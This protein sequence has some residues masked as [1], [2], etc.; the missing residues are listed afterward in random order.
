[1]PYVLAV[2]LHGGRRGALLAHPLPPSRGCHTRRSS[3]SSTS[4][5]RRR[6]RWCCSRTA[7]G[8][9]EIKNLLVGNILLVSRAE[10]LA[11]HPA[12]SRDRRLPLRAAAEVPPALVRRRGGRAAGDQRASVGFPVLRDVR[13]GGHQLR[14]HRRGLPGLLLPD[15]AGGLRRAAVVAHR[16]RLAIGWAVALTAGLT[17]LLLSTEMVSLDLPTGPTIVCCS[18]CPAGLRSDRLDPEPQPKDTAQGSMMTPT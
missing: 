9:E 13:A 2:A 4:S 8:D 10:V 11:D 1:M 3:A 6:R 16:P 18:D 5:P 17:G 12:L 7:S 15:R 14:P